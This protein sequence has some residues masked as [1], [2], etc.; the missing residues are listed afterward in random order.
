VSP[1]FPDVEVQL[2]G[3]DGNVFAIIG[4]VRRALKSAGHADAAETYSKA[5]MACK[6]YDEVLRLTMETV[7]VA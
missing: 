1:K 3:E 2:S 7:D 5:A 6:S 4:R